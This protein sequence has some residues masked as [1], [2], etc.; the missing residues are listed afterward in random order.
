MG[1][2]LRGGRWDWG[3]TI[4]VQSL[5]LP[6]DLGAEALWSVEDIHRDLQLMETLADARAC[7]TPIRVMFGLHNHYAERAS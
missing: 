5:I 1:L 4:D 6:N 3:F 7:Q 2:G